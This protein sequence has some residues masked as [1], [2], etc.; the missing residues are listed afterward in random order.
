ME[1][2]VET[3]KPYKISI[4]NNVFEN[5]GEIL[6]PQIKANA[7]LIFDS[8]ISHQIKDTIISSFDNYGVVYN[9]ITLEKTGEEI[10]TLGFFEEFCKNLLQNYT[11]TRKTT[12]IAIG[13]GTV[14]DFIGF[15][16]ATLMRGMPFI[17]IPTTLLSMVDSSVGGKVA[18]NLG[19]IK[20]AIGCFCQPKHVLIDVAFLK[21]LPKIELL[22]G[23]AEVLKYGFIADRN[24][25][26]FL[27]QNQQ[28]FCDFCS[29][30]VS[31]EIEKYLMEIIKVSCKIKA[32]VVCNDE[33]EEKGVR[34]VL[35]FGHTFAHAFEGMFLGKIPH[36]I[37]V[38]IGMICA[39][40]YS[41]IESKKAEEHYSK[42]GLFKTIEEF[43]KANNFSIPKPIEI[44]KFM[45]K[46]KKNNHNANLFEIYGQ[47]FP[48][49]IKLILL[50]EIGKAVVL[51]R[52]TQ[53]I[54]VFLTEKA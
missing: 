20:N 39:L 27:L 12:L 3:A 50:A 11:V 28:I 18:V 23:Y 44:L 14:G 46:D 13:G 54:F 43:C 1:I 5:F 40:K 9:M 8:Q 7:I 31:E 34:E 38:A 15:V 42:I 4:H 33:F 25:Y 6:K 49:K 51:E 2:S 30:N 48:E 26:D 32:Y 24:F 36:G 35:N 16:S 21:S 45:A 47:K 10:K 19:N 52:R 17:Q 22:S 37:A 53:D 41:K 29:G